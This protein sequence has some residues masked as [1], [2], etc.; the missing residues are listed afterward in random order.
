MSLQ[1]HIFYP[2]SSI[3]QTR[4]PYTTWSANSGVW[5]SD[6]FQPHDSSSPWPDSSN[7]SSYCASSYT[8]SNPSSPAHHNYST[9]SPQMSGHAQCID[10]ALTESGM[11]NM[12]SSI[13]FNEP[14]VMDN[15]PHY[16]GDF[17]SIALPI[18]AMHP[19]DI[20]WNEGTLSAADFRSHPRTQPEV[21]NPVVG[22]IVAPSPNPAHTPALSPR[23]LPDLAPRSP[24]FTCHEPECKQ[25]MFKRK[26]D[27][28]RHIHHIHLPADQKKTFLC[29]Y[30][31][32][33]RAK[34]ESPFHR[35]DHLRDHYRDYHKDE[36]VKQ[37][38]LP[39]AARRRKAA[40][41]SS[42]C[43][44]PVSALDALD[45][46]DIHRDWWRC[47]KCL[48]RLNNKLTDCQNCKAPKSKGKRS[49]VTGKV[50]S[51]K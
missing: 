50:I 7:N 30:R 49:G 26:A 17:S 40:A 44:V 15:G 38:T 36:V 8:S 4:V 14:S 21:S 22:F 51:K 18:D 29:D 10:P 45:L 41:G 33:N 47:A 42:S 34:M 23:G 3:S 9:F 19:M 32:C 39:A 6:V 28:Q 5:N 46:E 11:G 13:M 24:G 48:H 35:R 12:A 31:R 1:T 2:D 27:L 25:R 37:G 16:D 43:S 20:A